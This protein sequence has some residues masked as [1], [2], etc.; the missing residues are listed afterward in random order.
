MNRNFNTELINSLKI[1]FERLFDL[2]KQEDYNDDHSMIKAM[3][4]GF[5]ACVYYRNLDLASYEFN[6]Q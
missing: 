5:N 2:C 3:R 6:Q 4:K 1:R